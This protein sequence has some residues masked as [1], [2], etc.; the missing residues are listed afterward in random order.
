MR[1]LPR[2]DS[3]KEWAPEGSAGEAHGTGPGCSA[4]ASVRTYSATS[5]SQLQPSTPTQW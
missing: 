3:L 5:T 1:S 4:T 2:D